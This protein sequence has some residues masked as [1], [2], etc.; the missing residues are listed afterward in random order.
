MDDRSAVTYVNRM[1]GNTFV[2]LIPPSLSPLVV[3]SPEEDPPISRTP[4]RHTEY[5]SRQGIQTH[6]DISRVDAPQGGL[7]DSARHLKNLSSRLI[8]NQTQP[9]TSRIHQL[10]TRPSCTRDRCSSNKYEI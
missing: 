1:G 2:E 8:C 10:E 3:V 7:P 9:P 5:Y 4:T 6:G